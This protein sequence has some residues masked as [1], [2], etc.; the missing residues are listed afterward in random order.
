MN[1]FVI[2]LYVL[3]PPVSAPWHE[4]VYQC[5]VCLTAPSLCSMAWTCLSLSCMSYSPQSLLHG[6]NMFII[7]LY[8]LQ[9]SVSAPWH[10]HVY[11]CPVC[12]TAPSL[13]SMAWTCLSMS[14]MSYSPL[15]LLHGMNM[16]IND[17]YVLQPLVSA[18]WHEHVYHCPVCVTAPS[19][20]SM[21]WTCLSLSC[22]SYSP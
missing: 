9:P 13:C 2:V 3:Q 20:C 17:L 15:S 22:M 21:S 11:Q 8:V 19:L 5:P 7:L 18:P 16:S 12:L 10:E 14:C 4:H 1:M 6:M